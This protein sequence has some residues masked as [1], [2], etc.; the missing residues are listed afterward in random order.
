MYTRIT[1]EL[2]AWFDH[3]IKIKH[4]YLEYDAKLVR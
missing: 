1:S 3:Q 2:Q 4:N